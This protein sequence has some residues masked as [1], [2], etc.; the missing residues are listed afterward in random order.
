MALKRWKLCTRSSQWWE[1]IAER[2]SHLAM[3][4]K[5]GTSGYCCTGIQSLPL[6]TLTQ[7]QNKALR[8]FTPK[9]LL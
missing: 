4:G 3:A 2:L 6:Q 8:I 9:P 7:T 5:E 1:G